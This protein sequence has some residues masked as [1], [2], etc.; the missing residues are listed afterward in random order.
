ML[1]LYARANL[2]KDASVP[3]GSPSSTEFSLNVPCLG[4]GR[5]RAG[6]LGARLAGWYAGLREC[7]ERF[8]AMGRLGDAG[9]DAV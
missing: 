1:T 9:D 5:P 6:V 8:P 7:C 4:P 3:T 2:A